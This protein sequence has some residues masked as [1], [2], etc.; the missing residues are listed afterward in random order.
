VALIVILGR[1]LTGS[2]A[3]GL[4]AGLIAATTPAVAYYAQTARPYA[5]VFAFV[6]AATLT[7]VVAVESDA[8]V[9]HPARSV[10]WWVLYGLLVTVLGYLNELALLVLVAHCGSLVWARI[11]RRVVMRWLIAVAAGAVAITPL[12]V[13]S[14][15]QI[16]EVGWIRR[17]TWHVLTILRWG[18][19]A[20]SLPIAVLVLGC[21]VVGSVAWRRKPTRDDGK[22]TLPVVA[23]PVLVV[24][25]TVLIVVSI[26]HPIFDIRYVIYSEAGAALLA[27]AGLVTLGRSVRRFRMPTL[28]PGIIICVVLLL[29]QL[30]TQRAQ[31]LPT[32]RLGY[33][34]LV[35]YLSAKSRPKDGV[36]FLDDIYRKIALAYP[37][38]CRNLQDFALAKTP[39]EIGN[40]RGKLLSFHAIKPRL[41]AD[42]RVWTIGLSERAMERSDQEDTVSAFKQQGLLDS[43][44]RLV[45]SRQFA[46]AVVQLW[47]RMSGP[48]STAP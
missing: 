47:T 43:R 35:N 48:R 26:V 8:D 22:L 37:V 33:G 40:L 44:Y 17:P 32:S 31:H 42:D 29:G 18:F 28:V 10:W 30:P 34:P 4:F 13:L 24:P 2:S 15:G 12:A 41:L 6:V 7:L 3:A 9:A 11:E 21:A 1:H 19:F 16:R 46:D 27:G 38:Q 20:A 39:A 25:T 23:V 5:L 36:L 14:L 45:T